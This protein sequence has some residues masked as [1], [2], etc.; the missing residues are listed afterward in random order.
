M[1]AKQATVEKTKT[2]GKT[3]K[4][5]IAQAVKDA[6][7]L[8]MKT[9]EGVL[10]L[11]E[12]VG[13]DGGVFRATDG[14]FEKFGGERVIDTPLAESGIVGASIGLAVAG[15][16]PVAEVQFMGFVY[17]ALNQILA[18]A[19]RMRNRTMGGLHVPLVIRMPYGGGIHAPEHHSESYESIFINTPGLKVVIPSTPYDAKGLLIAAIRDDDPVIFM[20]PKLIYRAFRED[21]PTEPYMVPLGKANIVQQGRDVTLISYGAM[22]RVCLEA[23]KALAEEGTSAEIIDLRTLN[24]LDIE[25]V[26]ESVKKTGRAVVV[27][28]A[29]K[30]GGFGAELSALIS[31]RAILQLL[32]PVERAAGFDV[33]FPLSTLEKY[34]MPTSTR[35]VRAV[36]KT[37]EF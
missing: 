21:V 34:Y 20:E 8:E 9:D 25:T 10:V 7:W 22:V 24:P 19:A 36:K 23:A 5:T 16:R 18:H 11:G 13:V 15:F 27:H 1:T 33:T 12:D 29:P 4:L 2:G 37:L 17:P 26:I 30:T 35:V 32:A 6:L 14:L 31:E 3:E 28:E